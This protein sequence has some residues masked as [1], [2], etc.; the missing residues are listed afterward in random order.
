MFDEVRFSDK[1]PKRGYTKEVDLWSIGII[2]AI[3]LNGV[4]LYPDPAPGSA[5]AEDLKSDAAYCKQRYNIMCEDLNQDMPEIDGWT[6]VGTFGKD[7]VRCLFQ[8]RPEDRMSA[9]DALNHPWLLGNRTY[10]KQLKQV[11]QKTIGQWRP[12][13]AREGVVQ[14]MELSTMAMLARRA[15]PFSPVPS[16]KP[17]YCADGNTE[18]QKRQRNDTWSQKENFI[19]LTGNVATEPSP[20]RRHVHSTAPFRIEQ[21]VQS[22]MRDHGRQKRG[23]LPAHN[24]QRAAKVGAHRLDMQ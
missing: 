22:S 14:E 18:P 6:H 19:D 15:N 5:T 8:K 1:Q 24:H 2:T 21:T 16:L 10:G 23:D 11:N 12:G 13:L 20:K 3:L 4:S 17:C 7:F 9:S